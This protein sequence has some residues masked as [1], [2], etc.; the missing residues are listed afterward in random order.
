[1]RESEDSE[2]F[3]SEFSYEENSSESEPEIECDLWDNDCKIIPKII[4]SNIIGCKLRFS[5]VL[6]VVNW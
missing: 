6:I 2:E 4:S 3:E 5:L 1:M